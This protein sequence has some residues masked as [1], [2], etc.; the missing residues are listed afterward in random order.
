MILN[1][2]ALLVIIICISLSGWL[3][4]W[5]KQRVSMPSAKRNGT[6]VR[7][8]IFDC[9]GVLLA[10]TSQ[11]WFKKYVGTD[12]ESKR[13]H[14]DLCRPLDLGQLSEEQFFSTLSEYSKTNASSV[15]SEWLSGA[16]PDE[17]TIALVRRLS[18]AYTLAILSN[19]P[20]DFFNDAVVK[21]GVAAE[22][23]EVIVSSREGSIKPD[24]ELFERTLSRLNVHASEAI[25]FD[26]NPKNVEAARALGI[27]SFVFINAEQARRDLHS[28]GISV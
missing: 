17:A 20:V 5:L 23:D 15:R 16:I 6:A 10:E 13:I 2:W 28:V 21:T 3:G 11:A 4:Y 18:G 7:A 14:E 24:R 12:N 9:F 19:A 27:R 26:D 1:E 8:V 25:F 22:F